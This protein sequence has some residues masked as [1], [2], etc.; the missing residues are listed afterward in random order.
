MKRRILWCLFGGL[1]L[2]TISC[3]SSK[4]AGETTSHIAADSSE[5]KPKSLSAERERVVNKGKWLGSEIVDESVSRLDSKLS[6]NKATNEKLGS[7]LTGSFKSIGGDLT[8]SYTVKEARE[9]GR[10]III[11]SQGSIIEILE[12]DSQRS[13]FKELLLNY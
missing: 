12:N 11:N 5:V 2:A 7:L 8:A 4:Q 3:K 6:T 10:K 1:A 13:A 9:M